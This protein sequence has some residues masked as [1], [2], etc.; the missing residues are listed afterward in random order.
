MRCLVL[1]QVRHTGC[2]E[3][4]LSQFGKKHLG[5]TAAAAVYAFV[6]VSSA[7]RCLSVFGIGGEH[8]GDW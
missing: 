5:K 2:V 8:G 1:E 6:K 4:R 7:D 3:C